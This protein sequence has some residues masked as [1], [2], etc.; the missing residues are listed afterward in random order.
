MTITFF[1]LLFKVLANCSPAKPPPTITIFS[2]ASIITKI[3]K[4][5]PKN[6]FKL[7]KKNLEKY[8]QGFDFIVLRFASLSAYCRLKGISSDIF[9]GANGPAGFP[10]RF[11]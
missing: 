4:L 9:Q 3:G 11:C 6:G 2:R 1:L 5:S 7:D 8:F 10:P